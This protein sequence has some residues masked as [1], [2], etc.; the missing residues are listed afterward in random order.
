MISYGCELDGKKQAKSSTRPSFSFSLPVLKTSKETYVTEP[1]QNE[2]NR[3]IKRIGLMSLFSPNTPF[4]F[5]VKEGTG[6]LN[7]PRN[8]LEVIASSSSNSSVGMEVI[9]MREGL[10]D[11]VVDLLMPGIAVA[12]LSDGD[13]REKKRKEGGELGLKGREEGTRRARWDAI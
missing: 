9:R 10:I 7:I 6:R 8:S 13:W 2:R 11:P 12:A 5:S 1:E 4:R 3:R